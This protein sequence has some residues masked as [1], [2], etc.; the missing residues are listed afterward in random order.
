[1]SNLPNYCAN[2]LSTTNP[3]II[4]RLREITEG[5]GHDGSA[6][7]ILG[8]FV[9]IP[10]PLKR[11]CNGFAIIDGK[12]VEVWRE[13]A[14]GTRTAIPEETLAA[15]R[16]EFGYDNW[17]DWSVANWGTKWD[18]DGSVGFS[19]ECT[20]V[21]FDTAW[22]P[23]LEWLARVVALHPQ[24]ETLLAYAESGMGFFGTIRYVDGEIRE[25]MES[26]DMFDQSKEWGDDTD[27]VDMLTVAARL[28]WEE[29]GVC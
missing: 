22:A 15:W 7:N 13:D 29:F 3:A 20:V 1:M 8:A 6:E 24:G 21:R 14:D 25:E 19:P 17:Y 26:Q 16:G 10:E 23:P 9:P 12:Q 11:V 18:A 27:H 2:Y 28:H 4:A 5:D